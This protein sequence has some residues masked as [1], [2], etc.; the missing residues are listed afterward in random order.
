MAH[1][2]PRDFHAVVAQLRDFFV[3]RGFL[4][5]HV[6]NRLSIL[7]ACEDPGTIAEF[8]YG[9]KNSDIAEAK[10]QNRR[11]NVWPLP[12]TGQMWL[13]H[14]LLKDPTLPGLF[15]VTTSYRN[16]PKPVPGRH[17]VIFPLF[18]FECAG[19]LN[20][21]LQLERDLLAHLGFPEG[22][23]WD[24]MDLCQQ[25]GVTELNH[26]HETRMCEEYGPVVFLK[27]FPMTTSPFWN[28]KRNSD[29]TTSQKVDV[30]L[31][32]QE[33]FGTAERSCDPEEMEREFRTITEGKYAQTLYDR[34]GQERVET[35]LKEFLSYDF[36]P[37]FGGGIGMTRL[38]R[39]MKLQGLLPTSDLISS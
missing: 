18:E 11:E 23:E 37:R 2:L 12:Q 15:C 9:P 34:F 30:I 38:I 21:M 17:D 20:D 22:K 31:H 29:G 10:T 32:G 27:K 5:A 36:F 7:A 1:V 4:E 19:N 26:D 13:E 14:L 24:Y 3:K 8:S 35:E 33:T 6:Q 16:E 28:M 39:A 25:Y